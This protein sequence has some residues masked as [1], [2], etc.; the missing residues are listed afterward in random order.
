LNPKLACFAGGMLMW[1]GVVA[2]LKAGDSHFKQ[3]TDFMTQAAPPDE[4]ATGIRYA[5]VDEYRAARA[6]KVAA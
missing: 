1:V 3:E 4:V 6:E 5:S 2:L